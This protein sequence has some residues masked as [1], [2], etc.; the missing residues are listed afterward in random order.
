[1][2]K[3]LV[4]LHTQQPRLLLVSSAALVTSE[5]LDCP[6]CQAAASALHVH[7]ALAHAAA[8]V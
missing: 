4:A 3:E 1:M 6:I 7:A 2:T 8:T 5:N